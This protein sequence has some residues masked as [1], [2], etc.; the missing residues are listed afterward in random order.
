MF[1]N[2]N[3]IYYPV[4]LITWF[5]T[6]LMI[7]G[8]GATPEQAATCPI[9]KP[10]EQAAYLTK[11]KPDTGQDIT[12]IIFNAKFH[13]IAGDC[14]ITSDEINLNIMAEIIVEKIAVMNIENT[15][16]NMLVFIMSSDKKILNRKKIP[17]N[18]EF[19]DNQSN[20]RYIERFEVN[21]PKNDNQTGEDF[22]IYLAFELTHKELKFNRENNNF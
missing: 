5:I 14:N 3:L 16:A 9:V 10:L 18:F 4:A 13:R 6:I 8:C 20:I 21:I 17:L 1:K 7:S 15:N 2:I 11:F 12:D 19:N 22:I